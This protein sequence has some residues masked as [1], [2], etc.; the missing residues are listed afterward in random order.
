MFL[1]NCEH[2]LSNIVEVGDS[3]L[4]PLKKGILL[5]LKLLQIKNLISFLLKVVLVSIYIED[6]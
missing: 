5:L 1:K 6:N 3:I 2:S 4:R